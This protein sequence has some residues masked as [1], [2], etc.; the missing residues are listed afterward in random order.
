MTPRRELL[1]GL[2]APCAGAAVPASARATA[3]KATITVHRSPT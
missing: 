3:A 1:L 2:L